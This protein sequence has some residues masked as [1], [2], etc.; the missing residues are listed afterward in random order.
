MISNRLRQQTPPKHHGRYLS[1]TSLTQWTLHQ[2]ELRLEPIPLY[3]M[4]ETAPASTATT[5]RYSY[6]T[7]LRGVLEAFPNSQIRDSSSDPLNIFQSSGISYLE[8][9][10]DP[11]PT[12]IGAF[13]EEDDNRSDLS[14]AKRTISHPDGRRRPWTRPPGAFRQ[15]RA[16][17]GLISL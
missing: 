15:A 11:I 9:S 8:P 17:A 4:R 3:K 2:Y 1:S 7:A 14:G 6:G 10:H 5:T 13:D 16:Q 12:A